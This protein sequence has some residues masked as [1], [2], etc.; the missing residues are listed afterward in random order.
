MKNL[1]LKSVLILLT[2][3]SFNLGAMAQ[4]KI[5]DGTVPGT[6]GTP[7]PSAILDLES[8][9]KGLLLPR[10]ALTNTTSYGPLPGVP[11]AG[12]AVYNTATSGTGTSA[13]TPGYYY[14][15]GTVWVRI[16]DAASI[17]SGN[18]W[19]LTGNTSTIPG[20][21]F[22]GTKDNVGFQLNTNNT[23]RMFVT[24]TGNVGI[25]TTAPSQ[26]LDV[27]GN[28]TVTGAEK[29]GNT[30]YDG[31][32]LMVSNANRTLTGMVQP[33]AVKFLS[34]A[35]GIINLLH[36]D[37]NQSNARGGSVLSNSGSGKWDDNF[38]AMLNN[39]SA[40]T[41]NFYLTNIPGKTSDAGW[42]Y[43]NAQG[44]GVKGLGLL[45]YSATPVVL[46]TNNAARLT[47]TGV[48]DIGIGT[49]TPKNKL[50]I[51]SGAA[52]TS[53][54]TLTNLT[55]VS[56]AN[57]DVLSINPLTK[58]V[59]LVP[60]ARTA[61]F[62]TG[63][64]NGNFWGLTGNSGITDGLNFIGTTDDHDVV[65][66]RDNLQSGLLQKGNDVGGPG[67]TS[68]GVQALKNA[69]TGAGSNN[70]ASGYQ[71]LFS[72]TQGS[73]NV[74]NGYQAMYTNAQGSGNIADGYQALYGNTQG[75]NNEAVGYQ[76]M[77][78]NLTGGENAAFGNYALQNN[79]S[80]NYNVAIGGGTLQNNGAGQQNVAVGVQ[81]LSQ[82]STGSFNIGIGDNALN[83]NT[84]GTGNIAIGE[85]A[86][87]TKPDLFN[88]TAI[89]YSAHV[90]QS[91][92]IVLGYVGNPG[93]NVGIGTATPQ[94]R[95]DI[96]SLTPG[97]SGLK[98]SSLT[99]VSAPVTGNVLSLDNN[100]NVILVPGGG[101]TSG[102]PTSW[103]LTGNN[104]LP[105]DF[106]GTLNNEPL[107]F[108]VNSNKAG[109]VEGNPST[110]N[111]A[112]G[113]QALNVNSTGSANNAIGYNALFNNTAGE[114]NTATGFNSLFTNSTGSFNT[115]DG[116]SALV[117]NNGSHNTATGNISLANNTLGNNNVGDGFRALYDN[118]T[119]SNNTG[120][121]TLTGWG[122]TTGSNNTVIG[123]NVQGLPA[124]LSNTVILAD[125]SGNQRLYIDNNGN[126]G[127]GGFSPTNLPGA[128]LEVN[129]G[130]TDKAGLKLTQLK[131]TSATVASNGKALS[132]DANGNVIL[133]DA[134]AGTGTST[135]S[136]NLSGNSIT[137]GNFLGTINNADLIFKRNNVQAGYIGINN[138]GLGL[139]AMNPAST[140]DNNVGIGTNALKVVTSGYS[141]VAIGGNTL[142]INTSG[143]ENVA[144][145]SSA[146]AANTGG[147]DNVAVGTIAL[148]SNDE[149]VDNTALGVQTLYSNKGGSFN[150]ATGRSALQANSTGIYNTAN[151]MLSLFTNN[152]NYNTAVGVQALG[153]N[154]TGSDNTAIGY[155]ADV[156]TGG[157][158]NATAIGANAKVATSN[159]LVLGAN[160]NVGIGTNSPNNSLQIV[161][162]TPGASGLTLT[163]LTESP[164]PANY[165]DVLT[166]D[167]T[168]KKVILVPTPN[169]GSGGTGTG[170]DN[171]WTSSTLS[172]TAIINTNANGVVIGTGITTLPT[173]YKLYVSD[174]ILTEKIKV[175]VKSS[176]NWADNVFAPGYKLMSLSD[177]DAYI[178]KNQH[179]PGVASA[180]E[181]VKDGGV[182]VTQML[183]TQMGKIEELTLTL[184]EMNKRLEKLE[185]ENATL[186]SSKRT[187]K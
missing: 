31:A 5:K 161:S 54:L 99:T 134:T 157:L 115:A 52:G 178:K 147:N 131:S 94:N 182:D 38:I 106:L 187:K 39:G 130:Q 105:T 80:G 42:S 129:S 44:G 75:S 88:A 145:G 33:T 22:I 25:G 65:F 162:A 17:T 111:T 18:F 92:S 32:E 77:Q 74:A 29:I 128:R 103:L 15:N 135:N 142:S 127:F 71:A 10:V 83:G 163:S 180:D 72:N 40:Y 169:N 155:L 185:K 96:V 87:V 73:G 126:A 85:Q 146:L 95:L 107:N 70:V 53:G 154:T 7:T 152:G 66:R 1:T 138:I 172:S 110:A 55:T 148:T 50:D 104:T 21:N 61:L 76:A 173:G 93:T 184:I 24:N 150:T 67:N 183:S 175:A 91:N 59:I 46:G 170:G 57:T 113:Y 160:A 139:L 35:T 179:L 82:N 151:G 166:I 20:L 16:A 14:N 78:K 63:P 122:I 12:M 125:G 27:N 19:S 123:S 49:S 45:T 156:S 137:A 6:T 3:V 117:L 176:A 62:P 120:I 47:I 90:D 81:A 133:V 26:L 101:G 165:T 112:L 56:P 109:V 28:V 119:G 158:V 36:I 102:T 41:S 48:G 167:P 141:D 108:K 51:V 37:D 9:N 23:P 174:G 149:G 89:G 64:T 68:W 100:N 168:T 30:N 13:V 136:W 69:P 4:V 140:G 132:V 144:I 164:L 116:V 121:G 153:A 58:E 181:I 98:L 8:A 177:I 86:N 11:V 2:L 124:T 84:T 186:K 97:T 79:G 114:N 60:A 159:S 143:T 118:T 171:Y 34:S 43:L